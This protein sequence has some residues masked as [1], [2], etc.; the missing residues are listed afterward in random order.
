[1]SEAQNDRSPIV[2]GEESGDVLAEKCRL[3]LQQNYTLT[4]DE[5]AAIT[6]G[7]HDEVAAALD[8]YVPLDDG[9]RYDGA[10]RGGPW[11]PQPEEPEALEGH[12]RTVEDVIAADVQEGVISEEEGQARLEEYHAARQ[13]LAEQQAEAEKTR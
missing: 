9:V 6:G 2:A 11:V 7:T 1:M 10:G 3:E 5:L 4:V 13:N 12:I 8:A